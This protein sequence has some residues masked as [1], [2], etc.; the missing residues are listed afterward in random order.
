[1]KTG[2]I[3]TGDLLFNII[4]VILLGIAIVLA[5]VPFAWMIMNAFKTTDEIFQSPLRLPHALDLS[6]FGRAW[7]QA[8]FGLALRNSILSTSATVIVILLFASWAAFPLAR[9]RFRGSVVILRFYVTSIIISSQVILIPLFYSVKN[10]GI[11]NTLLSVIIANS[12]MGVPISVYLFW[13]FF[14]DVP[15]E[16]EE[17]TQIDG[18]PPR[19]FFWKFLLPLSRPII[20]TVTI[21][22]ALWTWNEYLFALTFLKS[23]KVMTIPA[24]LQAFFTYYTVQWQSL[25]AALTIA[26][27]PVIVLYL[28]MQKAFIKGLT[29]GAVKF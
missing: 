25:F 23:P 28:V 17:S 14:K 6:V 15:F 26:V 18:C 7:A 5:I 11:Y 16:I 19:L 2:S 10:L 29:A 21:F 8:S 3:R 12:T 22:Q 13:G 9:A 4:T 27:I 20:A 1:M 24:Q